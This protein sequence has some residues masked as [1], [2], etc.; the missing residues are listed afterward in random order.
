MNVYFEIGCYVNGFDK[1]SDNNETKQVFSSRSLKAVLQEWKL[2][3]YSQ[4]NYF[5]DVWEQE[6]GTFYPVADIKIE[7]W[8]F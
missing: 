3:N 1:D 4:P 6:N 8:I 7:D 2:R 5:I